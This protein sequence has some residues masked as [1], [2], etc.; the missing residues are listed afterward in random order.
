MF[1][2]W[3]MISLVFVA[4]FDINLKR[5]QNWDQIKTARLFTNFYLFIQKSDNTVIKKHPAKLVLTG[6]VVINDYNVAAI[7]RKCVCVCVC[8]D[9]H[10]HE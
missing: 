8:L 5:F 4:H 2:V 6:L 3:Y 10:L 1:S 7:F 9:Q